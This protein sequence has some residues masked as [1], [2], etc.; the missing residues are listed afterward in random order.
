MAVTNFVPDI[1]SARVLV[2][3]SRSA[4]GVAILTGH[5]LG[6]S[7]QTSLQC[8][9]VETVQHLTARSIDRRHNFGYIGHADH[10]GR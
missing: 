3:L 7:L 6:L 2:A 5:R 4:V 1:W 9:W 10:I 8:S